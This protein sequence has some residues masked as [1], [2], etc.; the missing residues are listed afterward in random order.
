[1]FFSR[2]VQIEQL[3]YITIRY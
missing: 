1:M 3:A 2:R